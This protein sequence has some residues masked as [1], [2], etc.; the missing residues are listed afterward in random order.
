MEKTAIQYLIDRINK[1]NHDFEVGIIDEHE[2]SIKT[3]EAHT[4]AKEMEIKQSHEYADFAIR[5]YI[6]NMKILNFDSLMELK[7]QEQ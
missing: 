2:W 1:V 4:Q 3:Y 5:C 7:K 6:L